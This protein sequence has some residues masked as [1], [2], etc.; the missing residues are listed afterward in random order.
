MDGLR[1]LGSGGS[2]NDWP[3]QTHAIDGSV[4]SW[5]FCELSDIHYKVIT[6]DC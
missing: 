5:N 4:G 6:G 2:W 3:N 1:Y